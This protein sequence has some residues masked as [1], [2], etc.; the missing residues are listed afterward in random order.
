[1]LR[2]SEQIRLYEQSSHTNV[3][4]ATSSSMGSIHTSVNSCLVI[5]TKTTVR[6]FSRTKLGVMGSSILVEGIIADPVRN[7]NNLDNT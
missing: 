1:M 2:K 4:P 5:K 3:K 7:T 6:V